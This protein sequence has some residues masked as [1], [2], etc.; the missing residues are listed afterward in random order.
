MDPKVEQYKIENFD[1][2]AIMSKLQYNLQN[3]DPTTKRS[4]KIQIANIAKYDAKTRKTM[5]PSIVS[6][7]GTPNEE[8]A[9]QYAEIYSSEREKV[10]K[11]TGL[12]KRRK[13]K[14]R[15]RKTLRK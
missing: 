2:P 13:T 5:D 7:M 8:Y 15:A 6:L 12:G 14:R 9:K 10:Y 3:T 4:S 1:R 11:Q